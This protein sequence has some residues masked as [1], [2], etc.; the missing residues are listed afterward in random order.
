[1]A[2]RRPPAAP[3]VGSP[4]VAGSARPSRTAGLQARPRALGVGVGVARQHLLADELLDEV[5]RPPRGGVIGIDDAPGTVGSGKDLIVADDAPPHPLQQ[6]RGDRPVC[7]GSL[8]GQTPH[9]DL[10]T[11]KGRWTSPPAAPSLPSPQPACL[12]LFALLPQGPSRRA[13]LDYPA[14]T[15]AGPH[16]ARH[17]PT[18]PVPTRRTGIPARSSRLA[19]IEAR[20]PLE[21]TTQWTSS[22]E[23]RPRRA[24]R[25]PTKTRSL[26]G[27]PPPCHSSS[28]RTSSTRGAL[29]SRNASHSSFTP[30][31]G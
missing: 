25:S 29:S 10:L 7:A 5:Q 17:S 26:P 14:G 24:G 6:R 9:D 30:P 23:S 31:D 21:H 22:S 8:L 16:R 20:C 18:P 2:P 19:A 3:L 4:P 13:E 15:S 28:W 11:A 12:G 27:I 1:M